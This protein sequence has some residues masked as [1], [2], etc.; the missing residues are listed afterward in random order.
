MSACQ[1]RGAQ[2]LADGIETGGIRRGD[3]Q[4]DGAVTKGEPSMLADGAA[5]RALAMADSAGS[6]AT[7]ATALDFASLPR[8]GD[9]RWSRSACPAWRAECI[10]DAGVERG[11]SS[12]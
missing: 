9:G 2:L 7:T 4:V 5:L 3:A 6:S 1:L 8:R 10:R 11:L 12:C